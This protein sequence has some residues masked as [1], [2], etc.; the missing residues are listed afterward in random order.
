VLFEDFLQNSSS[1]SLG[2]FGELLF[3]EF[4]KQEKINCKSEHEGGVDFIFKSNIK[5]DVKAVRHLKVN[6]RERFRRHNSEKQLADVHYAYII[7]WKDSVQ[8]RFE[9]KDFKFG[10]YDCFLKNDFV[11]NIWESYDKKSIKFVDKKHF[12]I[13]KRL[14]AELT[15]WIKNNLGIKARVIQR[16]FTSALALRSGGGWGADNF[17][18]KPPH[19]HDIVVL[20]SVA[21][22]DVKYIHSY[23]TS[24]YNKI[25]IVP[26]P[27]GTN[28][29][30]IFCYVIKELPD[31]YRFKDIDDFK[32]NVQKRFNISVKR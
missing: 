31:K 32:L 9:Y 17:Y 3:E 13:T 21:N 30:P 11:D 18:Q 15:D 26:K 28:R 25:P 29:K 12:A 20:L 16:N 24:E 8:L 23:P 7:F 2:K 22:N 14:K 1:Q 27:V 5:V 4:C 10:N 19:K 6:S